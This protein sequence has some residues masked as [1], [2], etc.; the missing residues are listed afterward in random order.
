MYFDGMKKDNG[1]VKFKS[2]VYFDSIWI[3]NLSLYYID[4][5]MS[6]L[7]NF[8]LSVQILSKFNLQQDFIIFLLKFMKYLS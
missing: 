2:K 5:A 6:R 4:C 1:K 8:Y 3:F 7:H